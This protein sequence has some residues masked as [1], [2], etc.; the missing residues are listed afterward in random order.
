VLHLSMKS[1]DICRISC[2]SR[3][4]SILPTNIYNALYYMFT[5]YTIL[6]A[7]EKL[8][9]WLHTISCWLVGHYVYSSYCSYW[10]CGYV[11]V[12]HGYRLV[13]QSEVPYKQS[14][15]PYWILLLPLQQSNSCEI[16]RRNH[17]RTRGPHT[18][19]LSRKRQKINRSLYL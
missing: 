11:L 7:C 13:K 2:D 18:K 14:S 17:H 9:V 19:N 10:L 3:D 8:Y 5:L 4:F 16:L 12:I 1:I 15:R 6:T